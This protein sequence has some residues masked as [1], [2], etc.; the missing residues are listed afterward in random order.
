MKNTQAIVNVHILKQVIEKSLKA[1]GA[2]K[3]EFTNYIFHDKPQQAVMIGLYGAT[4]GRVEVC[5]PD[6]RKAAIMVD[7]MHLDH[8][9]KVG[10]ANG[11][12]CYAECI[13]RDLVNIRMDDALKDFK[14]E[15]PIDSL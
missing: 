3:V 11:T 1:L 12:K 6:N 15:I 4:E 13:V 10:T 7:F 9:L 5:W 8:L 14:V 2:S